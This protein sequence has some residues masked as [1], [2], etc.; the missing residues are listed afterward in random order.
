MGFRVT[1]L[2]PDPPSRHIQ[3][4]GR[5]SGADFSCLHALGVMDETAAGAVHAFR[6]IRCD[7]PRIMALRVDG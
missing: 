7:S 1:G 4:P 5:A 6:R 3:P 2:H